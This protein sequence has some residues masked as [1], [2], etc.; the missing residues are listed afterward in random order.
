MDGRPLPKDPNPT[1]MGYPVGRWEGDTLVVESSGFTE[2]VWLDYDGHPHT[3][4]LR[5]IERY[6]RR[7]F[8]HL[9]LSVTFED[10]AVYARP[11]TVTVP[12]DL[13][14]DTEPL[15]AVCKENEKDFARMSNRPAGQAIVEFKVPRGTLAGYAGATRSG[16]RSASGRPSSRCLATRCSWISIA[17]VRNISCRC[18][19]PT[20]R[21][22]ARS[23]SSSRTARARSRIS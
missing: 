15:E 12:L 9:D 21:I 20:S 5:M 8:G 13:F 1:W 4:A 6:R 3:E 14:P 23:S 16:K 7:D 22:A 2:R 18:P 11:W 10:P 17:P 19:R